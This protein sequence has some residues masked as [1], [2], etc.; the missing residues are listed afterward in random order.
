MLSLSRAPVAARLFLAAA[1]LQSGRLVAAE[2]DRIVVTAKRAPDT[3]ASQESVDAARL[4]ETT[5]LL[6]PEDA[7]RYLPSLLVRQRHPGDT[8]APLATRTSGVGASA[9]SLIYADGILLSALIGN[10]NSSASPR[11]FMV[12]PEEIERVD[13]LYGPFSAAYPGNSIGAVVN[14]AT[15]QPERFEASAKVAT[16]VQTFAQYGTDGIFPA[17]Q[18]EA[19]AGDRIG[20]FSWFASA[21]RLHGR[22]QPLAY[23]TVPRTGAAAP[24]RGAFADVSRTGAPIWVIGAGGFEDQAQATLKLKLGFELTP[25]LRIGWRSGLFLNDTDASARTWLDGGIYAGRVSLGGADLTIP[26][27]AFSNNVYRFDER[28]WMHA[29]SLEVS[30]A[31]IDWR[32]IASLY[33]YDKDV[34]RIPSAALPAAAAGG[35]GALVRMDGTGWRTLDL[36]A[37][38]GGLSFGAHYDRFR[39]VSA[40][41]ATTD[42]R[43]GQAGALVQQARGRTRTMAL[44]AEDRIALGKALHLTL[45]ARYESW[46]AYGGFNFSA[47]PAL[48]VRQ[49]EVARS[50]LSPKA[51]LAWQPKGPWSVTL[52]AGQAYRFPTVQELYQ[53]ISTGPTLSVPDPNLR[54]E[55]ARSVELAIQHKDAGGHVRLSLFRERIRDALLSQ[56]APL[57]PGSTTLFSYVQNVPAVRTSGLEL[58]FDR[59]HVLLPQL[60]LSGSLTLVDPHVVHDPAF[61]AAIGKDIP[62]VP[63]RRATLVATWHEGKGPALTLAA[64]YASRS[65]A[66]I[67]NSDVVA[68]AWQGFEGYVLVDARAAFRV[69]PHWQAAVGVENLG[70]RRYFLFHPFPGRTFTAE[71]AWRF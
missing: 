69:G 30:A 50:D 71:L 7:V 62:Q 39:L 48:A 61:P 38:R 49:P 51:S 17:W 1:A 29:L 4:R 47:A 45:G 44:W 3:P 28:H 9:R 53:A 70:D 56:T 40:R 20:R 18:L 23:V 46:R 11:W 32:A 24:G 33:D 35:A 16:S 13:L 58:A 37:R 25:R 26:A 60:Q 42:W 15:R 22:S 36:D 8:Q 54:P 63:R 6:T 2:D 14:I 55:R 19:T 21:N 41:Y 65:Y 31:G 12:A 64:R 52:S 67:D 59:A 66:T 27:S 34:Q 43:R 68:H 10:N 57:A 5:A